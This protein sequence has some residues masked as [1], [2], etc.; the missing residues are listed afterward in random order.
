MPMH[1]HFCSNCATRIHGFIDAIGGFIL[2]PI[3]VFDDSRQFKPKME[4]FTDHGLDQLTNNG[5]IY[6][7]FGKAALMERLMAFMENPDQRE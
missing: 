3:D 7:S 6:K 1:L 2:F 4:I 5:S